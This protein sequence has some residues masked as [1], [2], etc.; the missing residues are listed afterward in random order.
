MIENIKNEHLNCEQNFGP[1][2][3][4]FNDFLSKLVTETLLNGDS[5]IFKENNENFYCALGNK[6]NGTLL[7]LTKSNDNK[8]LN[9]FQRILDKVGEEFKYDGIY[10]QEDDKTY[11]NEQFKSSVSFDEEKGKTLIVI[12][13]NIVSI[14]GVHITRSTIYG[15]DQVSN[16]TFIIESEAL[17]EEIQNLRRNFTTKNARFV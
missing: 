16:C 8:S 15:G 14:Y 9:V 12:E 11:K 3:Y 13:S 6:E 2:N 5:L 4:L 17:K 10:L 7:V 1:C